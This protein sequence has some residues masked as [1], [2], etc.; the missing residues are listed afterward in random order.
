MALMHLYEY[1]DKTQAFASAAVMAGHT[2]PSDHSSPLPWPA[3][4]QG[5]GCP[6]TSISQLELLLPL[7]SL[8]LLL[9]HLSV[10]AGP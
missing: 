5:W 8:I 7:L 1:V 10:C 9:L 3:G 4:I 2:L 6:C